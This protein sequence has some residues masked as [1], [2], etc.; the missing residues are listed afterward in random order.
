MDPCVVL[1]TP[2]VNVLRVASSEM[3]VFRFGSVWI[4]LGAGVLVCG[5]SVRSSLER[6]GIG[7]GTF[8]R[9]LSRP[10]PV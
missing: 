3:R 6:G 8:L 1:Y 9:P 7:C 5:V 4:G 2:T 10:T